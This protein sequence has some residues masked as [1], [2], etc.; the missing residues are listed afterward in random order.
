MGSKVSSK[1]NGIDVETLRSTIDQV[2]ADPANG[3][4]ATLSPAEVISAPWAS[5]KNT[6]AQ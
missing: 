1:I 5:I 3:R 2:T 6:G 4:T